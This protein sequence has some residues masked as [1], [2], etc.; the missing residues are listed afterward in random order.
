MEWDKVLNEITESGMAQADVAM[1]VQ[2]SEATISRIKAGIITK[3][4]WENGDTI[5]KILKRVR[6]KKR[7]RSGEKK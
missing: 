4:D 1:E 3:V 5:L 2:L 6:R 7:R